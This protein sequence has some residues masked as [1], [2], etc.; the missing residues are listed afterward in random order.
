MFSPLSAAR[1]NSRADGLYRVTGEIPPH[2]EGWTLPPG[3]SWG[4]EGLQGEHRHYQEVID[5]LGRSLSLVS[6]A[7][8]EHAAWLGAEARHLA[9]RNHPAIPTTYHYWT[10][11]GESPRGP[12]YL[13][14]WIAG[15]TVGAKLGR[16][17]ADDVRSVLRLMR[18]VGSVIAYLHDVGAVHGALSLDNIWMTPTGRIWLLGWQWALPRP[19]IPASLHPDFDWMPVP[20]EWRDCGWKPTS[21]SDQWQLAAVCFTA[22]TGEPPPA[23]GVPPVSLLRPDCP[24]GVAQVLERALD[25]EPENRFSN[26]ASMLRALDRIA[27]TQGLYVAVTKE[28]VSGRAP[29]SDEAR[30]RWALGD[31]YDVLARLGAGTFGSVWRVRDLSLGREVALKLLHPHI[32]R[33]ASAVARFRRE[34]RLAAQLAHPAIVPIYDWDGR[35]DITWYTME[36]AESGSVADLIDRSGPRP[37]T[38]IAPQVDLVLSGLSAAHSVGIVHRD[39]KPENILIDRYRRWRIADFGIAQAGGEEMSGTTG[40]PAFA[41]PE[42]LLGE[43]QEP[44]T[45]CFSLAA[46]VAYVLTGEPPFGD[47]DGREILARQLA[48]GA[49][50]REFPYPVADWL[51]V[52]L[53]PDPQERFA[54]AVAMQRAWRGAIDAVFAEGRELP[55]WRR[56]FVTDSSAPVWTDQLS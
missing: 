22:L 15:E 7:D 3:W 56:W 25:P 50:L 28:M 17:G 16:T 6:V 18:E 39:L 49:D 11:A 51:R 20:P 53:A 55:W 36:L 14:R 37:L 2:L 31:D 38:E 46:I 5:V 21:Q 9:H 44:G 26:V 40:T 32:A 19:D 12:G 42:Q 10:A 27:G 54:D 33:D 1:R 23:E 13:R 29:E 41:A 4:S 34:A 35:G 8:A 24:A 52:G 47:R 45:D 43:A 48:S 30:L